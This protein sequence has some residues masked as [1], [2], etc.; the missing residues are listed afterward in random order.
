MFRFYY[1]KYVIIVCVDENKADPHERDSICGW[2]ETPVNTSR[3][4]EALQEGHTI[5]KPQVV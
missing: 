1:I 3:G 2:F 4:E 5:Y